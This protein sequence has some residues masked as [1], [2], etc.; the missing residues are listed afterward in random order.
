MCLLLRVDVDVA[1][2]NLA[3]FFDDEGKDFAIGMPGQKREGSVDV[4]IRTESCLE[5]FQF[6]VRLQILNPEGDAAFVVA[7]VGD[8]FPSGLM[9]GSVNVRCLRY[10]IGIG[11]LGVFCSNVE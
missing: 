10:F 7:D 11:S 2:L 1:Q 6:L 9:Q 4:F 8:V 5:K 3:F